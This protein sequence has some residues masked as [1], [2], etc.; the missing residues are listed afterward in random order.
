MPVTEF[1]GERAPMSF[2][3]QRLWFLQQFYG[4]ATYNNVL[5]LRVSPGL[6]REA[7][8]AAVARLVARHQMLRV[9][10]WLGN[11]GPMQGVL[12]DSWMP[13][14]ETVSISGK[15][16]CENEELKSIAQT[17]AHA[18]FELDRQPPVSVAL[19]ESRS[20]ELI[21]LIFVVHHI[22]WDAESKSIVV[23]ELNADCSSIVH[24]E[25]RDQGTASPRASYLEYARKQR[26]A[27]AS[28]G[29][30]DSLHYWGSQLAGIT[31]I[32]Q[33]HGGG[34]DDPAGSAD[35][36]GSSI[37][38]RIDGHTTARIQR[39]ASAQRSTLFMILALAW[40]MLLHA[41]YGARDIVTGVDISERDDAWASDTIGLFVN[42]VAVRVDLSGDP[43]LLELLGRVRDA[44]LS[45]Y[46]YRDAPFD[47]VVRELRIERSLAR[48]PVFQTKIYYVEQ[49][50]LPSEGAALTEVEIERPVARHEMSLGLTHRRNGIDGYLNYRRNILDHRYC[51]EAARSYTEIV[52]LIA[53]R[54]DARLSEVIAH[55]GALEPVEEVEGD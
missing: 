46:E 34:Q 39:L 8:R 21:G 35:F 16:G 51:W 15:S 11:D 13:P 9:I 32:P 38:I 20:A 12:P 6:G 26:K 47:L 33:Q 48:D 55:I 52:K 49:P 19:V 45:A 25:P 42:Q 18:E 3:Q 31:D 22:I 5:L 43:A 53:A 17:Y 37:A 24:K 27:H 1:T 29:F 54:P 36:T 10:F 50:D 40:F 41:M 4:G 44:C 2:A 7:I 23:R 14:I 30:Q 28:G